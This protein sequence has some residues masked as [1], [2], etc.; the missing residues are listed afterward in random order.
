[1]RPPDHQRDDAR[2]LRHHH[3]HRVR[4]LGD[5]D[6][7]AVAAAQLARELRVHGQGQEA[8]GGGHAVALDDHRAVVQRR[9]RVEDADEQV[10]GDEGVEGDAGLDVAAQAH[11][12]LDDHDGA[13]ALRGQGGGGQHHLVDDLLRALRAEGARAA[14]SCPRWASTFRISAWKTT[15]MP[16]TT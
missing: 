14:G 9:A 2:L 6:G 7:G 1:M 10:V 13:R 4:V 15:M 11:V 16:N 5:A 8:G 3:R 12:A